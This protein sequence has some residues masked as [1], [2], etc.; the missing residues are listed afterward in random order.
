MASRPFPSI[1]WDHAQ[2]PDI[3]MPG[4]RQ[5]L[6]RIQ[7][8]D[9]VSGRGTARRVEWKVFLS[10]YDREPV[11]ATV[12]ENANHGLVMVTNETLLRDGDE[13]FVER[14]GGLV[15]YR[16]SGMRRGS[17]ENDGA[18]TRV[19]TIAELKR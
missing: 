4:A 14:N 11:A 16:L 19:V 15:G 18:D 13:V 10:R 6:A 2:L 7:G 17:R 3:D 9:G 12:Y 5:A 1:N 8:L